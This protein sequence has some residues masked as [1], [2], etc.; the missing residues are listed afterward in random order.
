MPR[1]ADYTHMGCRYCGKELALLKRLTG[2]GE[3][4]SEAHKRSYQDEYNRLALSRLLQAQ[5]VK[6]GESTGQ[7][8]GTSAAPVAVEERSS[9]APGLV[10]TVFADASLEA[11]TAAEHALP[12]ERLD[13]GAGEMAEME[14]AAIEISSLN[15]SGMDEV[16]VEDA[17]DEAGLEPTEIVEFLLDAPAMATLP[18]ETP[19]LES[20]LELS[21]GPA[22]AA[23]QLQ[24]GNGANTLSTAALLS[25]DLQLNAS[26][27]EDLVHQPGPE[28]S[29]TPQEFAAPGLGQPSLPWKV[30]A[31]H[32]LPYAS[33]VTIEVTVSVIDFAPD[34]S[35][36]VGLDFETAVSP[37]DSALLSLASTAIEFPAEDS[38]VEFAAGQDQGGSVDSSV[39]EPEAVTA[40]D[41]SPR[42]SLEA[43][44]KLHQDLIHEEEA[45]PEE[46]VAEVV[47]NTAQEPVPVAPEVVD[48]PASQQTPAG[49]NP[50]PATELLDI[51]I[52]MFPPTKPAPI[53][54]A[55][56]PS[57]SEP[58][59]PNLKSL[60]LRPKV[61]VASGYAPPAAAPAQAA[62]TV[63]ST[64]KPAPAQ[65]PAHA[66]STTAPHK[67]AAP[68]A[69]SKFAPA[70]KPG[71][72]RIAQP[73]QPAPPVKAES[74]VKAA[75]PTGKAHPPAQPAASKPALP[76]ARP[77]TQSAKVDAVPAPH[78]APAP[79]KEPP[80]IA[81][82]PKASP[83]AKPASEQPASTKPETKP[84]VKQPLSESAQESTPTFGS[85]QQPAASFAGSLKVKLGIAIVILVVA[86]STWLGWGGGKSSKSGAN[87]A[88]STDASGPSIIMGEGGWVEGWAGDPSGVHVG[89]QITIYRPSLKLSDYRIEFQGSIETQSIGWVFRAADPENYYALK[90]MTV[91]SGLSPKLA[92]FKYL[93]INGRQTQ[94]GRVP[95]DMTLGTDTVFNIRTDVRGPQ[96]T[97]LIQGRQVDVWTDDQLKTG[98]V[99]FLNERDERAKVKSVAIRYLNGGVK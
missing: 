57:Q 90:L 72:A 25:L 51:A 87:S 12:D 5:K 24:D 83:E 18:D 27:A 78:T 38:A 29:L 30:S 37:Q 36:A 99:G 2:G 76:T 58:L 7:K 32:Q 62:K 10:E 82:T 73:K 66:A 98:G 47:A 97:T 19:Y 95:I 65:T 74:T 59:L 69:P 63:P 11:A 71:A 55:G 4:C 46:V 53:A 23:W 13:Q 60:P 64:P 31:M 21:S 17:A 9:E 1:I 79:Q 75:A 84:P 39:A 70:S 41:A 68:A 45:A 85:M 40:E 88:T 94:V 33:P 92:L 6:Q 61:A 44:S 3:F 91:S 8:A 34:Q 16:A 93:V 96:F 81:A 67:D 20:W 28:A 54:G 14:S 86:C 89:R 48:P 43:L 49:S 50:G 52:R 15:G 80:A 22:V 42:A 35:T 77:E 26:P 56:L